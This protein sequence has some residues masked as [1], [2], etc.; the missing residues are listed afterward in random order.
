M[1][2]QTIVGVVSMVIVT[3]ASRP[4]S[5][6]EAANRSSMSDAFRMSTRIATARGPERRI[7]GEPLMACALRCV[8]VA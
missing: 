7:D 4:N 8:G 3:H 6:S 5:F 2:I 1:K